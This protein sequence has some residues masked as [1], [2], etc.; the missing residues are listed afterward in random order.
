MLPHTVGNGMKNGNATVYIVEDDTP[1]RES[2]VETLQQRGYR[3][4]A[5]ASAEEFLDAG[6]LSRPGCM[7]LDYRLPGINGLELQA[8]LAESN[9]GGDA[10]LPIIV[11]TG[12][13]DV[14]TAVRF[15][16]QG[17][18][19][20]LE[21]PYQVSQLTMAIDSAIEMDHVLSR[22]RK[23]F[24]RISKAFQALSNREQEV[25]HAIATG[26]LNKSIAKVLKVSVRTIETDRAH[27]IKK[28]NAETAGEVVGMYTEFS[29]LSEMGYRVDG[30]QEMSQPAMIVRLQ[31]AGKKSDGAE[32]RRY[33]SVKPIER[34]GRR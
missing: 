32:S 25:L 12:Y 13:A 24:E 29:L 2:L 19:T 16:E 7:V 15:M 33:L 34:R 20:L 9:A 17:A 21:K 23:R 10:L 22:V 27:I 8:K 30:P 31:V 1:G 6:K 28:F 3:C 14:P 11:T 26:K 5:F 4:R 18:V